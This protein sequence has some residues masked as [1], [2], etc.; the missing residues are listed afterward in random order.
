MTGDR[1]ALLP[2]FALA[3]ITGNK[4]LQTV[5]EELIS[6]P[7]LNVIETALEFIIEKPDA[8]PLGFLPEQTDRVL[9]VS[10]TLRRA[11]AKVG[12]NDPCPCGSGKKYK[13]C[14]FEKD[15][16]RLHHSSEVAGVTTEELEVM[17]EPFLTREKLE[18]MRG[19]KLARL[20]IEMLAPDLQ[21][22]FLERLSVFQQMDALL[23]AWEKAGWRDDLR[24][25]WDYCLFNAAQAGRRDVVARLVQLRGLPEDHDDIPLNARMLLL[26]EQPGKFLH[27]LE[28]AARR[29]LTDP[30]NLDYV[31][32]ACALTE[33]GLPGLGTLVARGAA[34][35]A[36]PLDAEM[37][38]ESICKVRDQLDLPPEDPGEWMLD[39]LYNLPEELDEETR[40][41]LATA[42]RQM[43]AAAAEAS[44]LRAQLAETRRNWN[45]RNG[46]PPVRRPRRP[47][48]PHPSPHRKFQRPNSANGLTNSNPRS[49]SVTPSAMR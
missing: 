19:P 17:P 13:K 32:V 9:H 47:Y 48:L 5:L 30:K 26:Q 34:A 15:Q 45:V 4:A 27:L 7:P 33:G 2:L 1:E 31:D 18:T 25:A 28:E 42:R 37:L 49:K 21:R 24:N 3:H 11:A 41:E 40:E 38:F 29:N 46:S 23:A 10:G 16:E 43:D 35:V 6:P 8:D 22:E 44:R 14:C 20:R 39:H 36:S 12:R